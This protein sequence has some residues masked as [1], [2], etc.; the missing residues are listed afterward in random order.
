[1]QDLAAL[2]ELQRLDLDN[3]ELRKTLQGIPENIEETRRNVAHIGEL[4][5]KERQRL[6][7]AEAWRTERER[8]AAFHG[9]LLGKSKGKLQAARN[10]KENKAAQREIEV[11]QRTIKDRDN[12]V[13]QLMGAIEQYR[14][15]IEEHSKEFAELQEHLR[16]LEEEGRVQMA[17]VEARIGE[18]TARRAELAGRVSPP[19][20][21][22]YERLHKR[23]GV[24]VVEAADGRCTGCNM[25]LPP[26]QYNELMRGDKL[27]T[28]PACVRILVY[29]KP[30]AADGGG[31]AG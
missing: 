3:L 16:A 10:E 25:S 9:E 29:R 6:G 1:M 24:A 31:A 28:C 17:D 22:Q 2:E 7:E 21:R 13:L 27:F 19:L 14:G 23:I 8:E 15:A 20:L 5:E 30:P 11:I 26:Q 4:L 12:E 18:T